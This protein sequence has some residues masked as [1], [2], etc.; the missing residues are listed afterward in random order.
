[1]QGDAPASAAFV[2]L[3]GEQDSVAITDPELGRRS[4]P[5]MPRTST[6]TM[7]GDGT[8]LNTLRNSAI[9]DPF[10]SAPSPQ[11]LSL[12]ASYAGSALADAVRAEIETAKANA[13]ESTDGNDAPAVLRSYRRAG[14]WAQFT[15]LSG[16]SFKNLY[17][18]PMLMLSHY[19]VAVLV[20]CTSPSFSVPC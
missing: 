2:Q 13:I 11:L 12:V 1:M 6:G 18:N 19:V 3:V 14:W 16:R 5:S 17:R 20:A 15:I 4:R 7:S 9:V 10:A 8:E